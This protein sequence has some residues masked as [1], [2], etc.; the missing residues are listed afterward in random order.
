MLLF[1]SQDTDEK[2]PQ[3]TFNTESFFHK[4]SLDALF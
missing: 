1:I 3:Y 4:E 2:K